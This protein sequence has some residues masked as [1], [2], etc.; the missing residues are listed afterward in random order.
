MPQTQPGRSLLGS[1]A[2]QFVNS[3][4]DSLIDCVQNCQN[5]HKSRVGHCGS[6]V[7]PAD[8]RTRQPTGNRNILPSLGLGLGLC[9]G[10]D[11]ILDL[12]LALGGSTG[13]SSNL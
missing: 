12:G 7:Q 9:L 3:M 11:L 10:L 6:N 4:V 1:V 2:R 13:S 8:R 5:G